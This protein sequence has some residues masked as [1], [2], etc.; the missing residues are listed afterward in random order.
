MTRGCVPS[1]RPQRSERADET[2][3]PQ[4]NPD[5]WAQWNAFEIETGSEDTFR[6]VSSS[7]S[8]AHLSRRCVTGRSVA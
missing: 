4:T 8:S 5:F 2:F 3:A 6:E 1:V 7:P